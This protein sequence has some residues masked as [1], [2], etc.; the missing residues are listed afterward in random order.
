MC[1][2]AL[3]AEVSELYEETKTVVDSAE[4]VIGVFEENAEDLGMLGDF[5]E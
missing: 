5:M 1:D 3:A 4:Q 2:T